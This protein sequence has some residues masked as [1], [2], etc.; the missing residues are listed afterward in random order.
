[1]GCSGEVKQYA[2]TFRN[3]RWKEL[4]TVFLKRSILA[5]NRKKSRL[6]DAWNLAE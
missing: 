1:M 4:R 5:K 3:R 6:G 2:I